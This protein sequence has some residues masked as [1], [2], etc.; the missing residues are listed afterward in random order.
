[1]RDLGHL[2]NPLGSHRADLRGGAAAARLIATLM[3]EVV[4]QVCVC[5]CVYICICKFKKN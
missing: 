4:V 1:M 5:V 2:P 3:P